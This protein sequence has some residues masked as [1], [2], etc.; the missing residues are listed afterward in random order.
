[1]V[2]MLFSEDDKLRQAFQVD[3]FNESLTSSIKIRR[4]YQKF[5]PFQSAR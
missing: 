3:C 5:E 2:E 1:M 4:Y